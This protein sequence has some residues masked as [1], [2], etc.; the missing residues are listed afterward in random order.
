MQQ[1]VVGFKIDPNVFYSGHMIEYGLILNLI[2][3][4]SIHA[5]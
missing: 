1:I 3:N 2:A 5:W 4:S